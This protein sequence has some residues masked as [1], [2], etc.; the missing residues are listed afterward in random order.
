MKRNPM[1][2][3]ERGEREMCGRKEGTR[4][5]SERDGCEFAAGGGR[6]KR[7]ALFCH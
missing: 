4:E 5:E 6:N 1:K 7:E 3:V 2:Q